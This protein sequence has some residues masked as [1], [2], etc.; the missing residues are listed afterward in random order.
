MKLSQNKLYKE[1]KLSDAI[2]RA[3]NNRPSFTRTQNTEAM[4]QT[5]QLS[6]AIR[7][8]PSHKNKLAAV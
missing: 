1:L 3:T 8:Y 6:V 7:N 5:V 2:Y 4:N